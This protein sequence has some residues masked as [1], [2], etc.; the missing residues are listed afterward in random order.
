[1]CNNC[2]QS[3]PPCNDCGQPIS[4][5]DGCSSFE[6]L[7]CVEYPATVVPVDPCYNGCAEIVD[8]IRQ[9]EENS[10]PCNL[11]INEVVVEGNQVFV[12]VSGGNG[13]VEYSDNG[14][15]FQASPIFEKPSQDTIVVYYVREVLRISC[16]ATKTVTFEGGSGGECQPQW[17]DVTPIFSI[18]I[19]QIRHK[20]QIDGCGGERFVVIE[21]DWTPTGRTRCSE[22][23]SPEPVSPTIQAD[24][25]SVCLN[26]TV[27]LTAVGGS[28]T[29]RWYS[30]QNLGASIGEG[31]TINVGPGSYVARAE[32]TCGASVFSNE[33]QIT[34]ITVTP[35]TVSTSTTQLCGS[36]TATLT[37]SG[38]SAGTRKWYRNGQLTSVTGNT[39]AAAVGGSYYVTIESDCGTSSPSNTIGINYT[40]DCGCTPTPITPS[41][42]ADRISICGT[43]VATITASGG[44]GTRKWYK[45]GQPLAGNTNNVLAVTE[46]GVYSA[47]SVTAC[48]ESL[49]SNIITV[50]NTGQ[51][52]CSPQPTPPT[53]SADDLT[54]CAN[55]TAIL[56][57]IGGAGD[58]IKWY[59]NGAYTNQNG[60]V[61]QATSQGSYTARYSNTCGESGD[62]NVL[63]VTYESICEGDVL[64]SATVANVIAP[65]CVNGELGFAV[66]GL[67]NIQNVHHV[68]WCEGANYNCRTNCLSN[69]NIVGSGI[70]SLNIFVSPPAG[71]TA[72]VY[73]LRLYRDSNCSV[74]KDLFVTITSPVCGSPDGTAVIVSQPQCVNGALSSA[75]VRL[76]GLQNVDRYRYCYQPTFNCNNTCQNP[77]AYIP[78]GQ[79]S[80]DITFS[81]PPAGSTNSVTIRLYRD[82]N[83][84][85]YKDV[86][87]QLTSPNCQCQPQP[88]TPSIV[89]LYDDL[90]TTSEPSAVC[91]SELARIKANGCTGTNVRWYN[92][93]NLSVVI[94]TADVISVPAG[95]YVARCITTCG[96]SALSNTIVITNSGPCGQGCNPAV[97]TVYGAGTY[98]AGQTITLQAIAVCSGTIR[99]RKDNVTLPQTGPTLT[100]PNATNTNAGQYKA[101]CDLGN[102]CISAD[103]NTVTIVIQP[104]A[105]SSPT[106]QV[107]DTTICG[108]ASAL[109]TANGVIGTVVW[110]RNGVATGQTGNSITTQISGVY[111]AKNSN[112]CGESA[113][114][115]AITIS[116]Q[117]NCGCEPAPATPSV[118]PSIAS[119]CGTQ[120]ATLTASGGNGTYRWYKDGIFTGITGTTFVASQG[121]SY[122]ATS[123]TTCGESA[124]S[125]AA[126]VSYQ[127]S[128]GGG[129]TN[130][131]SAT[132]GTI[133]PP[134]CSGAQLLGNFS[135][136]LNNVQNA[137]RY[138]YCYQPTFSCNNTCETPDG[139]LVVGTNIISL[140][141][142]QQGQSVNITIRIYNGTNCNSYLDIP[143]TLSSPNC[144]SLCSLN[145]SNSGGVGV[146]DNAFVATQTGTF[147]WKFDDASVADNL[148]IYRNGT[149]VTD[150]GNIS[151]IRVGQLAITAGDSVRFVINA[152]ISTVS[153]GSP[154][155][156]TVWT[157]V[158]NCSTAYAAPNCATVGYSA[159]L[160][161]CHITL[162]ETNVTCNGSTA[163]LRVRAR[164]NFSSDVAPGV[165]YHDTLRFSII[166][167]PGGPGIPAL[168]P[169]LVSGNTASDY[170][171][172]TFTGLA[173]GSYTV[174]VSYPPRIGLYR[175][176]AQ[177]NVTNCGSS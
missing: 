172:I 165:Y 125:S 113:A 71:G 10:K 173:P 79:S 163:S 168:E 128:C 2:N 97:P 81:P 27:T 162:A 85:I 153:G 107:D 5:C 26:D 38:G 89:R 33:I 119:I 140:P 40:T 121:G 108:E 57:A 7:P 68:S 143:V 86:T 54:I 122:T 37:A 78:S 42:S 44:N 56:T 30:K 156:S 136:T 67:S 111:T 175:S 22:T 13:S 55:Q 158:G 110:Y 166:G 152:T 90:T 102:G 39:Y 93:S 35:P 123:T 92:A 48:G 69:E 157:F 161:P 73:T 164:L 99:W 130:T 145:L 45:D 155:T 72:K 105:P 80:Y 114:S 124:L 75:I 177:I 154:N 109:L 117:A 146:Y 87:V 147:Y 16:F 51:C 101:V 131:P 137:D 19:D 66:I 112:S 133:I 88:T 84:S 96:E 127:P 65:Q 98:C 169:D 167:L 20:K 43:Q 104:A 151:G 82:E 8:I 32:N 70:T 120:T 150:A 25:T 12:N 91:G 115:N 95:N 14:V 4:P 132:L 103:S 41:I 46:S 9:L 106:I 62:S 49:I 144:Q 60:S 159:G 36:Q 149:L 3:Q 74:Y 63:T 171:Q 139:N 134:T 6:E 34:P 23:C 77:D 29:I 138:R 83:C 28:G 52:V 176:F 141:A 59:R 53:I 170:A 118:T 142:P 24:E 64:P 50:T 1:M 135:I 148:K 11:T 160:N 21:N 76:T 116:Y 18:C 129:N 100:L 126:T 174:Y 61:F 58:T 94:G 47:S 15:L 17:R 31:S